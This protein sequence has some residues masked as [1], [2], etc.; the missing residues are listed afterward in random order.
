MQHVSGQNLANFARNQLE[1]TEVSCESIQTQFILLEL[2]KMPK[3]V[4]IPSGFFPEPKLH[5]KK[6]IYARVT[7]VK[8]FCCNLRQFILEA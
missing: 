1:S 7:G 3:G 2:K 8:K 5:T 4:P 6:Q